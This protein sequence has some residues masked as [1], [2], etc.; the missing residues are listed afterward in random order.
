MHHP[1]HSVVSAP[2]LPTRAD[3]RRALGIK[4]YVAPLVLAFSPVFALLAVVSPSERMRWVAAWF[5]LGA[6]LMG[7]VLT[8]EN[9]R[10]IAL[11]LELVRRRHELPNAGIERDGGRLRSTTELRSYPLH[12]SFFVVAFSGS[13]CPSPDPPFAARAL[14][15]G[16]NALFGWWSLG[17]LVT[18]PLAL[19]SCWQGG[20]RTTP[21]DLIAA[22]DASPRPDRGAALRDAVRL[23]VTACAVLLLIVAACALVIHLS[24]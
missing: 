5:A 23:V 20:K 21:A 24:D 8:I 14:A 18:T 1:E 19:W 2:R 22:I 16:I 9:R 3:A 17:G 12:A 7:V 4:L 11:A 6:A 10:S 15:V 13:T